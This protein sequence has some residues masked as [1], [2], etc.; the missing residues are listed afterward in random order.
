MYKVSIVIPVYNTEEYL[1]KTIKSCLNQTFENLE[2]IIINDGS[3]DNSLNIANEYKCINNNIKVISTENRGLSEARNRGITEAQGKYIYFLDSDDSIKTNTIQECYQLAEEYNLEMVLFDSEVYGEGEFLESI[4]YKK[5]NYKR[6]QIVDS[7]KLYSGKEFVKRYSYSKGVLVPAWLVFTKRDF[8]INNKIIFLSN[9]IYEDVPF[10]Y[11]TMMLSQR[12]MYIPK[13]FHIRLYRADSIMTT[14]LN[15]RKVYSV[16]EIILEMIRIIERYKKTEDKTWLNYLF[17]LTNSISNLVLKHITQNERSKLKEHRYELKL[18]QDKCINLLFGLLDNADSNLNN[19]RI[20]LEFVEITSISLERFDEKVLNIIRKIISKQNTVTLNI[21][22]RLPFDKSDETMG[23][24]GSGQ[25]AR[26]ILEKYKNMIGNLKC[27]IVFI[28]THKKSYTEEIQEYDVINVNDLEKTNINEIVIMSYFYEKDMYETLIDKYNKRYKV[29]RLYEENNISLD[30]TYGQS[31]YN[32]LHNHSKYT[33]NR[34]ILINTP[35]HTN[36]GDHLIAEAA[37]SFLKEY[38]FNYKVLE[39]TNKEYK[40]NIVKIK[41]TININD[42]IIITG[43]G[44]FGSLWPYSGDNLYSIIRNFSNNKIIIMPQSM[45]F[46]DTKEGDEQK[47]QTYNLIEKHRDISICLR[48]KK[49]IS[50][51]KDYF[52]GVLK[53]YLFPDMALILN[54]SEE[55]F[56]REGV[57][58]CL[59][60]DKESCIKDEEKKKLNKYLFDKGYKVYE[61]SMH[62]NRDIAIHGRENAIN[63]KITEIKKAQLVITD[64]LHCM[65]S[66]VISGTPCIA[67]NNITQKVE[68]VYNTWLKDLKYIKYIDNFEDI[69]NILYDNWEELTKVNYYT[70]SYGIHLEELKNVILQ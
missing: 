28:D 53:P 1:E 22:K 68:G 7:R 23:I 47:K 16:Y 69:F 3:T 30:S 50:R 37:K 60:S 24:Y 64:T 13:T 11:H 9:A 46:E 52:G 26:A 12:I 19:S 65:I 2:I 32:R 5:D 31:I 57:L 14:S 51:F 59:R 17:K 40:E 67:L 61:T 10:N 55:Q 29:Y 43:G 41:E 38:L 48:E 36:I 58:L 35:E 44:F 4:E 54:Y 42:I 66:C 70:K 6:N 39:I 18:L 25:H 33:T 56:E 15:I 21:L 27:K 63:S 20:L 62:W 45:Y 8:L 49:S 34:I